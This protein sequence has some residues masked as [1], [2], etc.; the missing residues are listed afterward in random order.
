MQQQLSLLT[1]LLCEQSRL[2]SSRPSL[3]CSG[4]KAGFVALPLHFPA[5]CAALCE[6]FRLLLLHLP[7]MAAE[8]LSQS[9]ARIIAMQQPPW[10]LGNYIF[11]G[12]QCNVSEGRLMELWTS[13]PS[14]PSI[15]CPT[16]S[17]ARKICFFF[18]GGS[19]GYGWNSQSV[20]SGWCREQRM[21]I[22]CLC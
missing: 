4:I 16:E 5:V 1:S 9:A 3:P 12:S 6:I 14:I 19:Y 17:P 7:P 22:C 15:P 2:C 21:W 10:V 13:F 8:D 11:K 18:A 20:M